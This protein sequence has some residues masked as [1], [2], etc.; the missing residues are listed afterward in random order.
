MFVRNFAFYSARIRYAHNNNST[1][2][3][4]YIK[5]MWNVMILCVCVCVCE[6][7]CA[8]MADYRYAVFWCYIHMN[9]LWNCGENI[10]EKSK[11]WKTIAFCWIMKENR[12]QT[13]KHTDTLP[14]NDIF[15]F[16][17]FIFFVGTITD[18][19][20]M[21]KSKQ[22]IPMQNIIMKNVLLLDIF[23]STNKRVA[24]EFH[25]ANVCKLW[26]GCVCASVYTAHEQNMLFRFY[27][28][29]SSY[30]CLNKKKE[31]RN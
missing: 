29:T 9:I 16:V 10:F 3:S 24:S 27:V 4:S 28:H 12:Q 6:R 5:N 7:E 25:F 18:K 2:S 13:N 21:L 11:M 30:L 31:R 22:Y 1:A 8:W 19:F 17:Y 26:N 20:N 15:I 14:F 23:A